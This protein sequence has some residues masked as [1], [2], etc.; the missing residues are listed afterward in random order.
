MRF[1]GRMIAA[2]LIVFACAGLRALAD[3]AATQP[4]TDDEAAMPEAMHS[5]HH[6]IPA[7]F[8]LLTD[9]T[10][11]QKSQIV[12]IH[13]EELD[14]ERALR[15][16]EHDNI[17]ALLSDDQKKELVDAIAQKILDRKADQAADSGATTQPSGMN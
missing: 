8:N 15:A 1:S 11:D 14:Q 5:R 16:Q 17:M 3:S 4:S 9:L 6:K 2:F 10:D 12:K 13:N 7:P